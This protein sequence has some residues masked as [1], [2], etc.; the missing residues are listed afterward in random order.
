M[1]F[2]PLVPFY[3]EPETSKKRPEHSICSYLLRDLA[4]TRANQ[5]WCAGISYIPTLG[6]LLRKALPGGGCVVA[7]CTV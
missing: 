5:V 6:T 3:Q 7:F 1:K 4:I 2:M